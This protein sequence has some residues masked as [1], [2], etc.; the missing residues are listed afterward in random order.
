MQENHLTKSNAPS[1]ALNKIEKEVDLINLI[2]TICEKHV[3][4]LILIQQCLS[5][6]Y[7]QMVWFSI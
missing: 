7:L 4:N 1:K 5:Y 3:V 6:L 2:D